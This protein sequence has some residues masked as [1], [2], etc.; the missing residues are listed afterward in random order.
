[1]KALFF[2]SALVLSA[3]PIRAEVVQSEKSELWI[4][5][6]AETAGY[7]LSGAALGGAL[8]FGYGAR[9]QAGLKAA[10]FADT[11]G[12]IHNV[13]IGVLFRV[14]I[15]DAATGPFIQFS[16]GPVLLFQKGRALSVPANWGTVFAGIDCGWR[17]LAGRSLFVEPFIRGGYP[18]IVGAGAAMGLRW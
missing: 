3:L 12:L 4:A 16:G 6:S 13:E 11:S 7:S 9:T 17:F 1:M 5:P 8:A 2:I 15:L 14:F 18:Y 10:Y